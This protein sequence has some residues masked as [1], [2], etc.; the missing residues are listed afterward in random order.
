MADGGHK[1]GAILKPLVAFG[2]TPD[3]CWRWLGNH[4]ANGVPTKTYLG[5]HM[6]ARRWLWM[7][8]FGPIPAGLI[9]STMPV[10]G[11]KACMNP[12]HFRACHQADANRAGV[13]T[14][15]LPADVIEIRRAGKDKGLNTARVLSER[16]G[17]SAQAIRDVWRGRS[18][19]RAKPNHGPRQKSPD[20]Q[21]C[22]GA[23][24]S[25]P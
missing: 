24:A 16:M 20:R 14:V 9:V 18:W 12:W 6:P 4:D 5:Q 21:L 11:N 19:G 23:T 25:T 13:G 15:F 7:Q 8:L 1:P 10:C 17:C 3:E 22:T 2:K